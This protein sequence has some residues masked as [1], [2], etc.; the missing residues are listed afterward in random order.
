MIAKPTSHFCLDKY[1]GLRAIHVYH[2]H[3]KFA[4]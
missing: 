1:D 3:R 4:L 2:L